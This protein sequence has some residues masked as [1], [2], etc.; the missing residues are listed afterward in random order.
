APAG[1]GKSTSLALYRDRLKSRDHAVAW[2]TLEEEH[3]DPRTFC[4]DVIDA[5]AR[6]SVAATGLHARLALCRAP[7]EFASLVLSVTHQLTRAAT[8]V[9]LILDDAHVLRSGEVRPLLQ[10]LL[11]RT[12]ES[13]QVAL[14]GR[15][16][17]TLSPLQLWV[18]GRTARF[19][20]LELSFSVEEAARC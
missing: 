12:G 18:S 13:L 2:L 20:A 8:P 17:S 11:S 5:L 19:G 4:R 7:Q 1:F 6:C 10:A 9:C 14:A 15:G 16:S 3:N